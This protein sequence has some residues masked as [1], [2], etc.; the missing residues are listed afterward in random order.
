M[1][2][3]DETLT[4]VHREWNGCR[5]AEVHLGHLE[6]IHWFQPSGAPRP[7]AHGYI[8]CADIVTGDIP[9]ECERASAPHQLLVCMLKR[10]TAPWVY[11][12][13]ARRADEHPPLPGSGRALPRRE[14]EGAPNAPESRL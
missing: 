9:H 8:S 13:I 14:T 1:Q 10:H 11:R 5:T 4:R 7:L 2:V 6:N 12:E 3:H